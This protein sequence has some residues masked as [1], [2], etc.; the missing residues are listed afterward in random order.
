MPR[1]SQSSSTGSS[2]SGG[3]GM[4]SHGGYAH[5]S[6][7]N[8][9]V[10]TQYTNIVEEDPYNMY[11]DPPP[12]TYELPCE[13]VAM[14]SCDV[15]F[16]YNDTERWIEHIITQHLREKLPQKADCWFCNTF[17]F[18]ARDPQ[19]RNDR[20]QNFENR[21]AHIREHIAEGKTAND[22]CPDFHMLDHLLKHNLI[23]E[24]LY[25]EIRRVYHELPF[26]R[27]QMKGIF[28]PNFVPPERRRQQEREN[29]VL[30]D[31]KKEE[32]QQRKNKKD[33]KKR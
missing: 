17:S 1:H 12:G 20:R 4:S 28:K 10:A 22:M 9:T 8:Y 33:R 23:S 14:G 7:S 26:P 24:G 25:N 30:I 2:S 15:S 11:Q 13:F 16:H 21:M 19:V 31:H 27:D 5:S 18:D 6:S 32:R 29:E 3:S